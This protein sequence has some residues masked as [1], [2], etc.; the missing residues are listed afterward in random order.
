[1][2]PVRIHFDNQTFRLQR[3][4]GISKYFV[5]L[6]K[7]LKGLGQ[8]PKILG[9]F[10]INNYLRDIDPSLRT[11]THM[12]SFPKRSIRVLR[13][14]GNVINSGYQLVN[15]PN[16]IHETYFSDKPFLKG[17]QARVVTE[18]DALHEL[19]PELFPSSY[20][21]TKEKQA[22]FDRSDLVISISHHTKSDMLN[23]FNIDE[24]KIKVT[25]LAADEPLPDSLIITPP[26]QRRPFFLYVGIRLKHKNF[27]GFVKAFSQSEKLMKNFDIVAFC[28]QGFSRKELDSF[29]ALG[30]EKD[31]IRWEA[32]D[33]N[34]LAG[35]YKAAYAFV[36]P[37]L[38][39][40]FG[41][42]P[43]E[44]MG[45]NCPVVCSN[46]S[47]LPEVVGES[48]LTF[49]PNNLEEIQTQ[50]EKIGESESVRE[51]YIL[52]GNERFQQFSWKKTSIETLQLY[53]QLL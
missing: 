7:E 37:S 26:M 8:N 47:S 41:I 44:A 50:L 43:L 35:F 27:E 20:L 32:G 18:Y 38:Y 49:N 5:R 24:K 13:D 23:F 16:I 46:T 51:E 28:P 40:G 33:D 39:E 3:Y 19:F 4:G 21:K 48:A 42:P 14:L 10:Y 12:V 25:H 6:A 36:Y 1:M 15:P 11:G 45:Y 31:Q 22:A 34:K 2:N 9:G 53:R 30:F 29:Q 17:N 52:K